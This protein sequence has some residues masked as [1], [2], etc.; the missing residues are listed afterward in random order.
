[1]SQA[2]SKKC[3]LL[4]ALSALFLAAAVA[5]CSTV[6]SGGGAVG[7]IHLFGVPV[8]LNLNG[9]TVAN[10]IGVRIYASARDGSH[11]IAIQHGSLDILMFDNAAINVNPRLEKPLKVWTFSPAQLEPF[12]TRTSLGEGYQL[13][14]QW[15]NA[16][17]KSS[18]VTVV[19]RYRGARGGDV[20]SSPNSVSVSPK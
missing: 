9:G 15:G 7:E 5:G 6:G 13:A 17:P 1:M 10:G 3:P 20:Y 16:R 14:L 4:R 12:Q 18:V 19:A 11:G 2:A 8:A